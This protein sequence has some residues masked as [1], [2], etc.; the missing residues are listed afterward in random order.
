MRKR[1]KTTRREFIYATS[2]MA[3]GALAGTSW[4]APSVLAQVRVRSDV[5][6]LNSNGPELRAL[7]AA[8]DA[9]K[10][11]PPA[12]PKNW[13]ALARIHNDSCPH[14]NWF[15]L[16]WHRVYLLY[17]E[18]LCREAS[19]DA[20]FMLPYWDWT[21]LPRLPAPFWGDNNP[22][23]NNRRINPNDAADPI[24]VG[25]PVLYGVNGVGGIL[26]HTAF[27]I[28]A[29]GRAVGQRDP[30]TT[31]ELEG[32]PHNYIH[33]FVG[34]DMRSLMS[35]LDPI[36]WLHHA[37]IDRLWT[38]W[39]R[40]TPG[41]TTNDT[42][43]LNFPLAGFDGIRP[44]NQPVLKVTDVRSTYQLG[45]RYPTQPATPPPLQPLAAVIGPA[46]PALRAELMVD[47][48]ATTKEPLSAEVAASSALRDRL[49]QVAT[50][51]IPAAP[52]AARTRLRLTLEVRPPADAH[53][54]VRV[55]LNASTPGPNTSV[56]DPTYVGSFT[57]FGHD[58]TGPSAP[59][60]DISKFAFDATGT[61]RKLAQ[62]GWA[63]P[64][65]NLR[66]SLVPVAFRSEQTVEAAI[67][68][69]RFKLE[70]LD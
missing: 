66:V 9:L 2:L 69:V 45:Y 43:W 68:L 48:R 58:H 51:S 63:T 20:N 61:V 55:F 10:R 22:L 4:A 37:N 67:H 27:D 32:T 40:L 8:V 28:F 53:L 38:E 34:G 39:E 14:G 36:F 64:E 12:S 42:H 57:F 54:G 33:R 11:L 60:D 56:D 29:S 6:T 26:R 49:R 41:H 21:T 18:Q 70:A 16:P 15:F 52:G 44:Q 24:F 1:L 30:S 23:M 47:R 46:P 17:F 7:R 3:G 62:A 31:G 50:T 35:P 25:Q 5:A 13:T 65:A 59:G 19:G